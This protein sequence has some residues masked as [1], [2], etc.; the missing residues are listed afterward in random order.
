MLPRTSHNPA[1]GVTREQGRLAPARLP[2]VTG[3]AIVLVGVSSVGKT[4]VSEQLQLALREP[5]LHVGLDH[6]FDVPL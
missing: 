3:S 2:D 4:S 6:F 1:R 5:Y